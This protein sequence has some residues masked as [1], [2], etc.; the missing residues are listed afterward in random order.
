MDRKKREE[1]SE[2]PKK[3]HDEVH[4]Y[5]A[6]MEEYVCKRHRRGVVKE[7]VSGFER[8]NWQRPNVERNCGLGWVFFA[9]PSVFGRDSFVFLMR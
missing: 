9:E 1:G 6:M 4:E 7:M 8:G 3:V 5:K 2:L